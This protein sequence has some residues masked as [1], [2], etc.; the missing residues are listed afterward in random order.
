MKGDLGLQDLNAWCRTDILTATFF[1][2]VMGLVLP[3]TILQIYDRIIPNL[4]Y[5]TFAILMAVVASAIILEAV[6]KILRAR[7]FSAVGARYEHKTRTAAFRHLLST[8]GQ[9]FAQDS[10]GSYAEKVQ[11]IQTLREFFS[12]HVASL[13]VDIPFVFLFLVLIAV[14]AGPLVLIPII[15]LA[16]L[17]TIVYVLNKDLSRAIHARNE[18]DRRRYN[19]LIETLQGVHTVK[20]LGLERLMQR[21]YERLQAKSSKGIVDF[22]VLQSA[23]G[24]L[25]STFSQLSM[26]TYV[27]AG[28]YFVIN[29][30]L[31]L[32]GLAAGT[33][34]TGR[35]L[36]PVIRGLSLWNRYQDVRITKSRMEDMFRMPTE[37]RPGSLALNHI[38]GGIKLDNVSFG[39]E[40]TEQG[41]F[42]NVSLDIPAGALIGITGPNGAGLSTFMELLSGTISPTS[43]AVTIDGHDLRALDLMRLRQQIGLIPEEGDIFNGTFLENLTLFREGEYV[44]RAIEALRLVGLEEFVLSLPNG[45]ETHLGGTVQTNLPLGVVQ[46]LIIARTIVS[47]PKIILFDNANSG[48]DMTSDDQLRQAFDVIRQGRT[49]ILA[50][51]R[52]SYLKIC[53]KVYTVNDKTLVPLSGDVAFA[54]GATMAAATSAIA[55]KSREARG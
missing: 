12:G 9:A 39:Y 23:S 40:N 45:L 53:D 22:S 7:I 34:L 19:F 14:V 30:H 2:N 36:Q 3:M 54:T 20:A 16:M 10:P 26:V 1:I 38:D 32:G 21:R 50:T 15:L 24:S 8:N 4:A 6:F 17:I 37:N 33:M 46:K 48:L 41:L 28:S 27:S 11:G 55:S 49:V 44:V 42:E 29:G 18:T 35:V 5:S 47:N 52:P 13:A 31:T 43:G 25:A 51:Y